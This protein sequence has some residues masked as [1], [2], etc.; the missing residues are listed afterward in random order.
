M[1]LVSELTV[2]LNLGGHSGAQTTITLESLTAKNDTNYQK[3][4]DVLVC[5]DT[6]ETA[7]DSDSLCAWDPNFGPRRLQAEGP[8]NPLAPSSTNNSV[9]K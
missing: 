7:C 5:R 8:L 4:A 2:L 1:P 6:N 3:G 9:L